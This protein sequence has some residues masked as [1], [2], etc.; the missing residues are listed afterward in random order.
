MSSLRDRCLTA[1]MDHLTRRVLFTTAATRSCHQATHKTPIACS[2]SINRS[3]PGNPSTP[4]GEDHHEWQAS[5]AYQVSPS[6][7]ILRAWAELRT[8]ANA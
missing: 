3:Q 5:L 2:L 1:G 4:R 7:N 6:L 8:R